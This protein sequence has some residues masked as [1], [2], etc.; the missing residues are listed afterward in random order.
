M[1]K[2]YWSQRASTWVSFAV[3]AGGLTSA[4][5]LF[6]VVRIENRV[7]VLDDSTYYE[8]SL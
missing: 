4:I 7:Q 5:I 1:S 6:F 2:E 8:E 3:L